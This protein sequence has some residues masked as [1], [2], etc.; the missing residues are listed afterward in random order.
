MKFSFE[1]KGVGIKLQD[2]NCKD[3]MGLDIKGLRVDVT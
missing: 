2:L 1:V 3:W